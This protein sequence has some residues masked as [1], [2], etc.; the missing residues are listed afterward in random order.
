[1]PL[2]GIHLLAL[3]GAQE[4]LL[5]DPLFSGTGAILEAH[6]RFAALGAH[7]HDLLYVTPDVIPLF[8]Y[9]DPAAAFLFQLLEQLEPI[10]KL[11]DE[12]REF[13][14]KVESGVDL[15]TGGVYGEIK[16]TSES[17]VTTLITLI[18]AVVVSKVDLWEKI[19]S[20]PPLAEGYREDSGLLKSWYWGDMAHYRSTGN[21]AQTLYQRAGT[22]P[23]LKAFALGAASHFATD[24]TIHPLV[25]VIVGSIFRNYTH[26]H[27]FVEN[28]L[29]AVA[30]QRFKKENLL[31]AGVLE[32]I[33]LT[34]LE[35]N[36]IGAIEILARAEMPDKL[37]KLIADTLMEVYRDNPPP[38][39]LTTAF[40]STTDI[41]IGYKFF[42]ML[43]KITENKLDPPEPPTFDLEI[44]K[45]L[46]DALQFD[47]PLP[48][49]LGSSFC[50]TP[51]CLKNYI[52]S[53][54]EFAEWAAEQLAKILAL[55]AAFLAELTA[56]GAK[57]VLYLLQMILYYVYRAARAV[58]VI[59]GISIPFDSDE[60]SFLDRMFRAIPLITSD[61]S[62]LSVPGL[63]NDYPHQ[64]ETPLPSD[65]PLVQFHHIFYPPNLPFAKGKENPDVRGFPGSQYPLG[66]SVEFF[67]RDLPF[68]AAHVEDLLRSDSPETTFRLLRSG[69][70]LGNAIDFTAHLMREAV[71]GRLGRHDW[72]MDA[73][74]GYAWRNWAWGPDRPDIG[75]PGT[76]TIKAFYHKL[77]PP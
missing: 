50:F 46:L 36:K 71:M 18:E 31:N 26:R 28:F 23:Q 62:L 66:E 32:R 7:A 56:V 60:A 6:P 34:G 15:V 69:R 21:F 30:W 25:N 61:V 3:E 65:I 67:I 4:K 9:A 38:R 24:A 37:A 59:G 76:D 2:S 48:P 16:A 40:L 8:N 44:L 75:S 39:R 5:A 42:L 33:N 12:I 64:K 51:G 45:K 63:D 22:D 47:P 58:L 35:L 29:D 54:L 19:I 11:F 1:M 57:L 20:P 53:V 41:Q 72:N 43:I 74:R 14:E 77:P 27:H 10:F 55:S 13:G 68:N 17:V 52:D 49:F 70:T 73:D